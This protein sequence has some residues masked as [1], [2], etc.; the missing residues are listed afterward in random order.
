MNY[1]ELATDIVKKSI[2]K[3]AA[4]S[5]VFIEVSTEFQVRT[6]KGKIEVLKQ[7]QGSGLGLRMFVDN[8]LG[9]SYTSDFTPVILETQIEKT[10]LLAR[11]SSSDEFCGLPEKKMPPKR[12]LPDLRI[13]D[14]QIESV[15]TESKIDLA[16]RAEESA[17]SH[18]PKVKNS[19]GANFISE[20]TNVIIAN[21]KSE[22]CS[23]DSTY[24]YLSCEP[25]A[26]DG[27]EKRI[28]TYWDSKRFFSDLD[29][30]EKIGEKASQRAE[31][32]LAAKTPKSQRV[33]VILE[34][35][36]SNR[37]L[38]ALAS[39]VNGDN[40]YKKSS[41]LASMLDKKVGSDLVTLIDDGTI[42]K[43]LGT[44][45]FDDEGILTKRKKIMDKGILSTF[46][47]DTYTANKVNTSS[48]GNASRGYDQTPH[49]GVLNFYMEK[50]QT[51][52]EEMIKGVKS[53]FF[54]TGLM[55][56]GINWITGDFS[57]MAEG[58]WIENGELTHPV[59]EVT[60]GGTLFDFLSKI[61]QVGNDLDFRGTVACP[62]LK[63]SKLVI[64]GK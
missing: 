38:Y 22:P 33:P 30:P 29:S 31:R 8:K 39:A 13:Y 64:G 15:D 10:L 40:V 17:F 44:S 41:F 48:T 25:V 49:I 54:V 35:L 32:M 2:K 21:S 23:Y 4:Q 36:I 1:L 57:Q 24:F 34:N 58:I 63:I 62:S 20:K 7:S 43:G 3:G 28:G 14:P 46:L 45:P 26:E 9:F 18:S 55:G 59:D 52:L 51:P 56:F 5:E 16:K 37:F 61:E 60:L 19:E 47:Y 27:K 53:G 12:D 11:H 50:G 6:R 42:P